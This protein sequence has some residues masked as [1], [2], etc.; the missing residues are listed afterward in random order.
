MPQRDR[1][2]EKD[3]V[4][5]TIVGGPPAPLAIDIRGARRLELLVDLPPDLKERPF[6]PHANWLG[7]ELERVTSAHPGGKA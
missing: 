1:G 7:M 6:A 5:T 2:V 4:C 3:A